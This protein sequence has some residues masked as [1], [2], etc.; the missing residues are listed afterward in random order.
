MDDAVGNSILEPITQDS[1]WKDLA[2]EWD[3]LAKAAAALKNGDI[4]SPMD[5]IDAARPV[6]LTTGG[7]K[8]SSPTQAEQAAYD[9]T[10]LPR[11]TVATAIGSSTTIW[12]RSRRPPRIAAWA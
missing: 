7:E 10:T 5:L 4:G 3:R 8:K 11:S 12:P 1:F 9:L 6:V 2:A